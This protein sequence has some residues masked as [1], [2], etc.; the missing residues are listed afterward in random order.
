[1]AEDYSG[2]LQELEKRY[3]VTG[4]NRASDL[5]KLQG[6]NADD[7]GRVKSA[8]ESQYERRGGA[9]T[10][11][12]SSVLSAQGYGSARGETADDPQRTQSDT[13]A[14]WINNGGGGNGGGGGG[15]VN[16]SGGNMF[17]D[18]YKQMMD[19][20]MEESS[21]Q[22][23]LLE[24]ERAERKGRADALFSDLMGRAKQ[25]INVTRNDAGIGAQADAFAASQR[26]AQRNYLS[27]TAESG[28]PLANMTGERR[29]A[30]ERYGATTGQF[31][32]GLIGQETDK[33]RADIND[34]FRMASGMLSGDQSAQLT[35]QLAANDS[36]S[37]DAGLGVQ[38]DLG[39][40]GND[41]GM[42]NLGLQDWD[43][44][45]YWDMLRR[46]AF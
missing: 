46:G 2:W 14:G 38:Y 27:D 12:D 35:Q 32:A 40:R 7:L 33:R 15:A 42:R 5:A 18:W 13:T 26:R 30:A 37:R 36:A 10:G 11:I 45:M 29:M 23:A 8:L 3:S 28:G 4:D 6:T 25:P 43:R 17:P 24:A 1:M 9:P 16:T 31:E 39:L 22:R 19:R 21:R 34:A 41:L 20:Q 44:Q